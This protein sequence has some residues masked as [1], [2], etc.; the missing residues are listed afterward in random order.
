MRLI[1]GIVVSLLPALVQAQIFGGG[2]YAGI[3][4]S[5]VS[6]DELGGFNKPGFWGGGYVDVRFRPKSTLQMEMSFIQKGSRMAPNVDNNNQYYLIGLN[7]I[8]LPLLYRWYGIRNMSIELGPQFGFLV[9]QSE[10]NQFGPITGKPPFKVFELSGAVG[11]SYFF[12]PSKK[13]EVNA[14]YANSILP[15]RGEFIQWPF[16]G[17]LNQLISF[18]IRWWFKTTYVAPPKKKDAQKPEAVPEKEAQ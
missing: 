4:T 11:L 6:G 2:L 10:D 12:L 18:S 5:Q 14:R 15:V 7:Y 1:L 3:V 9:S 17:Q 13:L 8:E 16:G